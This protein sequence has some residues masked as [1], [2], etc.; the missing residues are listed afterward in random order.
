MPVADQLVSFDDGVDHRRPLVRTASGHRVIAKATTGMQCSLTVEGELL[1][2][3][4]AKGE[5]DSMDGRSQSQQRKAPVICLAKIAQA[6][7]PK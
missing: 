5:G 6:P 7:Y 3:T 2:R 1:E 4:E